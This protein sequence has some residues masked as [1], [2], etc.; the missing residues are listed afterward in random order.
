[1]K[2]VDV[3][4]NKDGQ[5]SIRYIID[6]ADPKLISNIDT[7]IYRGQ[8]EYYGITSN[9]HDGFIFNIGLATDCTVTMLNVPKNV[10]YKI[11]GKVSYMLGVLLDASQNVYR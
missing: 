11:A 7:C 10:V 3:I 9:I 4:K 8:C 2:S 5:Y 1:M 6:R